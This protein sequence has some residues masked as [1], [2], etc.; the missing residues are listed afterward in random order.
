MLRSYL[1]TA[2]RAFWR[3]QVFSA[4]NILGLA[5][6]MACSL[7]ILL[8]IKD[9][10]SIGAQY[11]NAPHLYRV[12]AHEIADGRIAT[13]E[14]TPGILADELKRQFPEVVYAAGLSWPE[15]HVL[16]VGDRVDR[17]LGYYAGTDW[18]HMYDIPLLAGTP[19]TALSSPNSLA[20]SR[21]VAEAYFGDAQTALGK[22]V[23]F[24]NHTDYQVTAVF[25]NLPANAPEKYNFLLSWATF[26]QREPWLRSGTTVVREPGCNCTPTRTR[27]SSMPNSSRF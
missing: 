27:L 26:L 17:Y 24:D 16:T 3:H 25:E 10:L 20:L 4:I 6:G 12:M 11:A 5:T 21:R 22:S 13:S 14:D 2:L 1:K 23:R 19:A 18:F 8:W 7:L 9:E 15:G